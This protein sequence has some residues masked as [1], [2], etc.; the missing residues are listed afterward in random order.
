MDK[1][2]EREVKRINNNRTSKHHII[3]RASKDV[4]NAVHTEQNI[5][6]LPIRKHNS[7]HIN[8]KNNHPL[9][10]LKD[11][12]WITQVMSPKAKLLYDTLCNM[13]K[14]DFYDRKFLKKGL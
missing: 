1:K 14:E 5:V 12:Q 9:E 7:W 13:S 2:R 4:F 10:T 11:I 6:D 8:Q 3:N